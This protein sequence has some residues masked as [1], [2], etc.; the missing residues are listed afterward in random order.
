MM[1]MQQENQAVYA[2]YGVSP[3]GSCLPLVI[4]M[5]ILLALYRVIYAMPAYVG[6]IK[7]A[8]FPLVDN[9]I[10]QSGSAEFI[11]SFSGANY[12][13]RQF[14]NEKNASLIFPTQAGIA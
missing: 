10:A 12:F 5:P 9:L 2:K 6:K 1:A 7:E 11:Q 8:F 14:S 4:Q 13:A 3:T